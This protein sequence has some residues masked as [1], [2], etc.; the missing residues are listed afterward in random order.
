MRGQ[1]AADMTGQRFGRLVVAARA[2]RSPRGRAVWRC[3]CD[4]GESH[5]VA[6]GYLRSGKSRSC[7]CLQR[8]ETAAR[9]TTH[10]ATRLGQRWPEWGV[11]RQMLNRCYRR[12]DAKFPYYGA[13]G[14]AVCERWRIGA[15]GLTG[16]QCFVADMGRR[17]DPE[18][19]VE[20]TDNDGDY[21]PG[22][23]RWAT[24][25][26]QAANRRPRGTAL[27]T[28]NDNSRQPEKAA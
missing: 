24:R 3:I 14:I 22:N 20:R 13:R 8:E 19:T 17:P 12:A 1:F 27:L 25:L 21:E 5:E 4:C 6:G 2:G 28:A 15:E 18:L 26:E 7:G 23:C 9:R 10:G 16:F 11:W